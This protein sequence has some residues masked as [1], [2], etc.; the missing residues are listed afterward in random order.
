LNEQQKF[1]LDITSQIEDI[2]MD[3]D[4]DLGTDSV[5]YKKLK[6]LLES[7]EDYQESIP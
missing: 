6:D 3:A 7:V 1:L 2:M 5:I 4:F